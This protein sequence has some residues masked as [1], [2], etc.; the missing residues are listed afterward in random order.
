[1]TPDE[2]PIAV[3]SI[4]AEE[5]ADKEMTNDVTL[6]LTFQDAG[7][8]V[9]AISL[10]K[11]PLHLLHFGTFTDYMVSFVSSNSQKYNKVR[12][13]FEASAV[14][15]HETYFNGTTGGAEPTLKEGKTK[16]D[17][18]NEVNGLK[19]DY[20]TKVNKIQTLEETFVIPRSIFQNF[21]TFTWKYLDLT[22]ETV[23]KSDKPEIF[24]AVM[25]SITKQLENAYRS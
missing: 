2:N 19:L 21:F 17:W 22:Q 13:E 12:Q 9:D 11:T 24:L 10:C 8:I 5:T 15:L 4:P 1:M 20:E 16:T 6:T 25:Y 18:D 14:A 23:L 7:F 3:D